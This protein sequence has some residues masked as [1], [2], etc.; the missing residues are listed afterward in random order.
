MRKLTAT[1]ETPTRALTTI[2]R[3]RRP[4]TV[5]AFGRATKP[6]RTPKVRSLKAM[7]VP[8]AVLRLPDPTSLMAVRSGRVPRKVIIEEREYDST[9]EDNGIIML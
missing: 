4:I 9:N 1:R 3:P 6:R 5:L 7:G 2:P 8:P